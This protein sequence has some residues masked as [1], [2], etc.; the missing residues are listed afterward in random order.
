MVYQGKLSLTKYDRENGTGTAKYG[1]SLADA[2]FQVRYYKGLLQ[3]QN[4]QHLLHTEPGILRQYITSRPE[5]M[6]Q[7]WMQLILPD[8]VILYY[9]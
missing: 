5:V 8:R 9:G 2:V 1:A 3:K 6:R 7:S 4:W